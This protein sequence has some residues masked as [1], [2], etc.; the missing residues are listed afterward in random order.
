MERE[1]ETERERERERPIREGCTGKTM[2][3]DVVVCMPDQLFRQVRR[4]PKAPKY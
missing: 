3:A 1:R 4:W 2:V